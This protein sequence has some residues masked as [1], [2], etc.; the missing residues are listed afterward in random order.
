[1]RQSHDRGV[2]LVTVLLLV[3]VMAVLVG[4]FVHLNRANFA[5][6]SDVEL[7]TQARQA[8][9]TGLEFACSRLQADPTWGQPTGSSSP[10][11]QTMTTP[12]LNVW[13]RELGGVVTVVGVTHLNSSFQIHFQA[14]D[15]D[16]VPFNLVDPRSIE[17][18]P[19][20]PASWSTLTQSESP[21]WVSTNNFHGLTGGV[22][23]TPPKVGFRSLPGRAA[24]VQV[25]G[26]A[27]KVEKRFDATLRR[28][29]TFDHS[30]LAKGGLGVGLGGDEDPTYGIPEGTY[31]W[32]IQSADPYVNEV[33][34][35]ESIYS[36]DVVTSSSPAHQVLFGDR[37]GRLLSGEYIFLTE[38]FFLDDHQPSSSI[39]I[40][41]VIGDDPNGNDLMQQQAALANS[42]GNYIANA[43][44]PSWNLEPNASVGHGG[45]APTTSTLDPGIYRIINDNTLEVY[46]TSEN[47]VGTYT[48]NTTLGT[49]PVQIANGELR[50]PENYEVTVLGD[51]TMQ[52]ALTHDKQA[53]LSLGQ[54]TGGGLGEA[55]TLIV[56]GTIRL[57]G[58]VSGN[59]AISATS[60]VSLQGR[61]AVSAPDDH[62][63][64]IASKATVTFEE[65]DPVVSSA[66]Q[67]SGAD[68]QAFHSLFSA[69]SNQ[70][71]WNHNHGL[72]NWGTLSSQHRSTQI[73][74]SGGTSFAPAGGIATFQ[75]GANFSS[76]VQQRALALNLPPDSLPS[77][78]GL[79]LTSLDG[80][81]RATLYL[82]QLAST[83]S[84]NVALITPADQGFGSFTSQV[85]ARIGSTVDAF[86]ARK[87]SMN[88]HQFIGLGATPP[89]F[90]PANP[91]DAQF[92]GV[93]F[94]EQGIRASMGGFNFYVDGAMI[95]DGNIWFEEVKELVS[96]YNPEMVEKFAQRM[97]LQSSGGRNVTIVYCS[98]Y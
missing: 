3:L 92:K 15:Q 96:R 61:S 32:R 44:L 64:A 11:T 98:E 13:E 53:H 87:G 57:G 21:R 51:F 84:A 6:T 72:N 41:A 24:Q 62:G 35:K 46:D 28:P 19:D 25:I 34:A 59:G 16:V 43:S 42:G 75:S 81:M 9:Q 55:T 10:W 79:D 73:R 2:A 70:Q 52:R 82:E 37:G 76:A 95:S 22:S 89:I 90:D 71:N 17:S 65:V 68:W 86:F 48:D 66:A 36:P 12:V 67:I 38:S 80:Y 78:T 23:L 56:N 39:N 14:A 33:A 7:G 74:N 94:A 60:D 69:L 45:P 63:L 77:G 30:M 47:Y 97:G 29:N 27:G 8:C 49:T 93:I 18:A 4:S 54:T 20:T 85:D 31:A 83:G 88:L 5:V 26:H 58:S 91:R 1:M 40:T 50:L